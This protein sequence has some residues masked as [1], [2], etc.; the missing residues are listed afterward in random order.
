MSYLKKLQTANENNKLD[1]LMP[2]IFKHM[3]H[4]N[5]NEGKKRK[6]NNKVNEN[7]LENSDS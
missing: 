5:V 1:L 2:N 7:F 3:D 6:N 4:D